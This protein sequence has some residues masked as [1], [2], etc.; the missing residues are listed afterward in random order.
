MSDLQDR[1]G[2]ECPSG[3]Q[4]TLSS[5]QLAINTAT[6]MTWSRG[7]TFYPYD[8]T[9]CPNWHVSRSKPRGRPSEEDDDAQT[10]AEDPPVR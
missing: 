7:E 1:S 10:T 4:W 3:K 8:C 2:S 6:L 9:L 5:E